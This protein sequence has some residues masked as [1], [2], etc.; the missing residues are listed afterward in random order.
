MCRRERWGGKRA[1][2]GVRYLRAVLM[3]AGRSEIAVVGFYLLELHLPSALTTSVLHCCCCP[4]IRKVLLRKTT[5]NKQ[6]KNTQQTG[7]R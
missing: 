6:R 2:K 3:E 4:F 5:H 1:V 7:G